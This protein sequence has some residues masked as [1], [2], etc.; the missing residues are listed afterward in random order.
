MSLSQSSTLETHWQDLILPAWPPS[1]HPSTFQR[2]AHP[3]A[4]LLMIRQALTVEPKGVPEPMTIYDISGIG[5]AYGLFLTEQ[6]EHLTPLAR[7]IA[8]HYTVLAGKFAGPEMVTGCLIKLGV[9]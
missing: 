2:H 6:E 7:A 5:G 3:L 1:E 4:Q 9:N 8:V